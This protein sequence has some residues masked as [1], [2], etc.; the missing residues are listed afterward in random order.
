[1]GCKS[2]ACGSMAYRFKVYR[3]IACRYRGCRYTVYRYIGCRSRVTFGKGPIS[4]PLGNRVI[5]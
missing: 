3:S 4:I 2:I 1:M 5:V